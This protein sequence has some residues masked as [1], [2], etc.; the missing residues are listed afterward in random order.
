MLP[1]ER[2]TE[3]ASL[4]L[5]FKDPEDRLLIDAEVVVASGQG[6]KADPGVL[7]MTCSAGAH[8]LA[9]ATPKVSGLVRG[10]VLARAVVRTGAPQNLG[11]V[12]SLQCSESKAK[13]RGGT[14]CPAT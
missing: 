12:A 2:G 10:S 1:A 3:N 8:P 14:A 7:P 5:P 13:S 11:G 6:P 9:E 4:Y